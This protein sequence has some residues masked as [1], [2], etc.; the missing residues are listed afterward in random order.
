MA[1]RRARM[2]NDL[3]VFTLKSFIIIECKRG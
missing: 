3:I 1:N 2:K